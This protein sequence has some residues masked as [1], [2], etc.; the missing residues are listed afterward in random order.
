M[1][2]TIRKQFDKY[3]T[4][5]NLMISH[6]K[7]KKGKSAKESI[8]KFEMKKEE[9]LLWL[10]KNLKN[11]TYKHG[12]YKCF[13]VY[14]PKMRKIESAR[15]ID[16][17]VHRWY[18]D[19]FITPYFVPSFIPTTY[20]C[21]KERGMHKCALDV[22]K[23]MKKAKKMWGE[24]YILK[25]DVAKYFFSIDKN[26]LI[27]ILER[28]IKDPK[29]M[30]LTKEILY[31]KKEEVGIPIGN[32]TSQLFANIYLNEV[33][34]YI[35]N[36]LKARFY[37]RYMDDSI[38]LLKDK[39]ELKDYLE[40]IKTFL[41]EKLHLELNNKTNI[42]KSKQGV[43][44]CGYQINEYRLKI[45]RKGKIRLKRKIKKLKLLVK[46]GKISSNEARKYLCG[47]LGYMKY[48]NTYFLKQKLFYDIE[49]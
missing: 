38:I 48:A 36:N 42:F 10:Y 21:I 8:V 26:V 29:L 37:F 11:Q 3:L 34:Q 22:Q 24:Y 46:N 14:D 45:R 1:P 12:T 28:K 15:Y 39:E 32:Y 19:F 41:K 31:S 2:K 7:S 35:K 27:E 17:V 33:D 25:M 30:W 40:K 4:Y 13:Y 49:D 20:A 5:E 43:N 16:R 47:H 44:F 6:Q 23:A 9:Y 18:V